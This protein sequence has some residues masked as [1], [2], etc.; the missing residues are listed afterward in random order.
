MALVEAQHC[1]DDLWTEVE[2][3]AK[4]NVYFCEIGL[5]SPESI[6]PISPLIKLKLTV[7][8]KLS[9]SCFLCNISEAKEDV[10]RLVSLS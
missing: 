3:I 5:Q 1:V 9:W 2:F 7:D 4:A 6:S 10:M 8:G